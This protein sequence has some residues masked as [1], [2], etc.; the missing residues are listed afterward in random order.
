MAAAVGERTPAP[1]SVMA[2]R[3]CS[4]SIGKN[5]ARRASLRRQFHGAM[6]HED[7]K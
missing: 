3:V 4:S 7:K 1:I 2:R 6:K 5:G